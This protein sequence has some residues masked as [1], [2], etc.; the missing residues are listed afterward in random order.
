MKCV[1]KG[2]CVIEVTAMSA[3]VYKLL[4]PEFNHTDTTRAVQALKYLCMNLVPGV[5]LF[6]VLGRN[7]L[8]TTAKVGSEQLEVP[9]TADTLSFGP[10]PNESPG[11]KK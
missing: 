11:L 5:W 10:K 9:K 8:F 7:S 2:S 1:S 4:C 6:L 3:I